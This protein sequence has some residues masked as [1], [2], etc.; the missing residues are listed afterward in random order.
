MS[1]NRDEVSVVEL[2]GKIYVMG[3]FKYY[4]VV[5]SRATE[6]YDPQSD[7]WEEKAALPAGRHH[8]AAAVVDG[9]IYAIGGFKGAWNWEFLKTWKFPP[10]NQVWEYDPG[11]DRWRE[12]APMPTARGALALGVIDGKIYAVGGGNAVGGGT[13]GRGVNTLEMYDPVTDSWQAL[14]PMPTLRHHLAGAVMDG[15]FY[16]IGGRQ[17]GLGTS[18]GVNEVFNP[19]T[20]SWTTKAPMPLKRS[21]IAAAVLGRRI[22]IFGGEAKG[23]DYITFD[24]TESYGPDTDQWTTHAPMANAR[25]GLGAAVYGGRIYVIGGSHKWGSVRGSNTNEVFTPPPE[26]KP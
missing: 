26:K 20:K 9:K 19:G 21:G 25:H 13:Y 18:V 17:G 10:T 12:R 15:R 3:G 11:Q 16:A 1:S 22:Y 4:G 7:R 2:N 24:A 23:K 6:V 14:P 5:A 8:M